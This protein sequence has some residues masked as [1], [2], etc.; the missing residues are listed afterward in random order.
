LI[1]YGE[2]I[3]I[4]NKSSGKPLRDM[5]PGREQFLRKAQPHMTKD[6]CNE[7]DGRYS[8]NDLLN[9]ADIILGF[10]TSGMKEA[11]FTRM[12]VVYGAWGDF[13]EEI[14]DTL[15]PLHNTSA[16]IFAQNKHEMFTRLSMLVENPD[17]WQP[18]ENIQSVR[19]ILRDAY[20]TKADGNVSRRLLYHAKFYALNNVRKA[21][22]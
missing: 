21:S 18:T 3:Q 2:K 10:Q 1:K 8:S 4:V 13:F 5:F 12:P 15:L 22:A 6:N 9:N 20:F 7:L 17:S 19:D 16:L 14:K 11:M